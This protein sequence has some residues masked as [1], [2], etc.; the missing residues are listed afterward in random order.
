MESKL[1]P[2]KVVLRLIT[3]H[4]VVSVLNNAL[5]SVV[6][7]ESSLNICC[8][9]EKYPDIIPCS[10]YNIYVYIFFERFQIILHVSVKVIIKT[11]LA[12]LFY[13]FSG[14]NVYEIFF[15]KKSR[16]YAVLNF[17]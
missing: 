14:K 2:G 8:L 9:R 5:S 10:V 11:F 3:L 6:S 17:E 12:L 13:T 1:T 4:F 7:Y 16:F 15:G